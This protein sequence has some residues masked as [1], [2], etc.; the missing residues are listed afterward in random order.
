MAIPNDSQWQRIT[1]PATGTG[2]FYFVDTATPCL[3]FQTLPVNPATDIQAPL[4]FWSNASP[5]TFDA[6]MP[7][8]PNTPVTSSGH[9]YV[10]V[11]DTSFSG[12]IVPASAF[13]TSSLYN[14]GNVGA[15]HMLVRVPSVVGGDVIVITNR[16]G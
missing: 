2:S 7:G 11:Q 8:P 12:T 5:R 3:A 9:A 15:Q 1:V 10:W 13:V 16:K 6:S 14:L 4:V